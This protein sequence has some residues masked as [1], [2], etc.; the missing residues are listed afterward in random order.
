[1]TAVWRV[2]VPLVV[3]G[4]KQDQPLTSN[5][6]LHW[7][8]KAGYTRLIRER[9]GWLAKAERIPAQDHVTVQLHYLP[10]DNRRRDAPN[11]VA[12]QKPA[13]DALVDAGIVPDDTAR[14]V[15]ELMPVIHEGQGRALWLEITAGAP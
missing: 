5:A 15:T 7:T 13:V 2:D 12:S 1:M 4:K 3:A 8:V 14:W 11:L 10:G 9:V 6:R